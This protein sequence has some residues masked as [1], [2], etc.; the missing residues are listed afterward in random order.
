V[1]GGG[2]E[3]MGGWE[4]G[5]EGGF[6]SVGAAFGWVKRSGAIV[7]DETRGK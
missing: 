4:G 2:K 7:A 6:V 1:E 5:R 3:G